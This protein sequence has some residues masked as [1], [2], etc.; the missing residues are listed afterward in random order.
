MTAPPEPYTEHSRRDLAAQAGD[1]RIEQLAFRYGEDLPLL[2]ERLSFRMAPGTVTAM[3]GPSGCGKSTLAKLL[4]G[5]YLP[6]HGAIRLDGVD[7]RHLS[8]N[9]LRSY[10][11]VVPQETL[12]FS[13]SVRDNLL[14]AN[15]QASFEEM[16]AACKVA[17]I[18][19]V[20]EQLP[21]GYD[22]ELGERGTGL[23]GGQ[24]QRLAIARALL[25]HPKILI[26]DEAIANLDAP[27]AEEFIRTVNTLHGRVTILFITHALPRSLKVD[28]VVRLG[29]NPEVLTAVPPGREPAVRTRAAARTPPATP[30]GLP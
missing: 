8:A 6:T 24:K 26:F 23:S 1:I 2:Y 30:E 14:L 19:E 21:K 25:K 4:Q 10:F 20:I 17:Q 13:G 18:H 27:T 11:G 9:E 22:S 15:P 29:P 5:F 28:Q 12:L 7:A 3:M 16:V